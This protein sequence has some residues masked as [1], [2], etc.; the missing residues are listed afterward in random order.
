[1]NTYN[2]LQIDSWE[3]LLFRT[4]KKIS[5]SEPQYNLISDRYETLQ[6]IISSSSNE[7]LK[8]AHIFVQGSIRLK[9]ALKP[10]PQAVEELAT[11]DADAIIWLPNAKDS[12]SNSVLRAIEE[13]FSNGVRVEKPIQQL[14]RGIRIIYSDEQPGFHIDVTPARNILG[15]VEI[16]GEGSLQ[17]PD[18]EHGWKASS[19]IP[20][21]SWLESVA[22]C[23]INLT[24]RMALS[25]R[26]T[27]AASQDPIPDYKEYIDDNPLRA[28]IKLLKRH[29]DE[30]AI[31]TKNISFRP[32]SAIITTLAANAYIKVVLESRTSPLRPVE[33]ILKIVELMPFQIE[34]TGSR[35]SILNPKDS[36][37]NFAEKWNLP[38]KGAKYVEAF[39][40][41]HSDA[42]N[43][44]KLGFQDFGSNEAFRN[45]MNE[46]FGV[47]IPFIESAV[48]DLPNNWTLPGRAAGTTANTV[49][50]NSL[51]G[52]TASMGVPQS[53]IR[54]VD[55]LG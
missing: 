3:L 31:R 43:A 7:I 36:G 37:E 24:G 19:P 28:A 51:I 29:R 54:P 13:C 9:T 52:G 23:E 22:A 40:S 21:S 33:A 32:I 14:R 5:L 48:R 44:I 41:W 12:D 11:I 47:P 17:V 49:R 30:W 16:N 18:R 4:A 38:D 39:R 45:A 6:G 42:Q 46:S 27:E 2:H 15:S 1:M 55:R 35:Y 10:A 34:L 53:G 8:D 50:L 20:Y 25:S 26:M